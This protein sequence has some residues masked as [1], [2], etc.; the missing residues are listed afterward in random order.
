MQSHKVGLDVKTNRFHLTEASLQMDVRDRSGVSEY[1]T[2]DSK[3][4]FGACS[5]DQT[6]HNT[7][8]VAG[9]ADTS[10]CKNLGRNSLD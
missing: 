9:F 8:L 5:W 2:N 4:R 6:K 7:A 10:H 1:S 3:K